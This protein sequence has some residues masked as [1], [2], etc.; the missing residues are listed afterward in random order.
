MYQ[1]NIDAFV[2]AWNTGNFAGLDHYVAA[3]VVRRSP[4]ATNSSA[5]NFDELK[6]V[7]TDFRTA[8]PDAKVTIN[9]AFF[10]GERSI[11]R[12]TFTGTNTGPGP[13]PAT[14]KKVK[15]EGAS[16]ARYKDAKLTEELVYFDSLEMMTQLGL[17]TLPSA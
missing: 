8:Y 9:E 1:K 5:G 15:I 6:K 16:I 13:H 4:A 3:N 7:I 2:A 11:A 12:W 14:G 17:I 10:Q